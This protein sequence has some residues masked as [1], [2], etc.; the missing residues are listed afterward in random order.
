MNRNPKLPPADVL[1]AAMKRKSKLLAKGWTN[2]MP[3][4]PR[5]TP[6][7]TNYSHSVCFPFPPTFNV[8]GTCKTAFFIFFP[9]VIAQH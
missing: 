8:G 9:G 5:T 7:K 1:K 6:C 4:R 2:N 3:P